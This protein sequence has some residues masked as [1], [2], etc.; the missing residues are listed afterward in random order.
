MSLSSSLTS[1]SLSRIEP[2]AVESSLRVADRISAVEF[3]HCLSEAGWLRMPFIPR[4]NLKFVA[5]VSHGL[6]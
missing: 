2:K 1:M 6:K 5:F 4:Q 3:L